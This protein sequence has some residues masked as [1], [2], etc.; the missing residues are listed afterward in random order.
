[1]A[2]GLREQ[3]VIVGV[4]GHPAASRE[5]VTTALYTVATGT[6]V[7]LDVRRGEQTLQLTLRAVQPPERL[8][9]ELLRDAVGLVT[10]EG[11]NGLA[12]QRVIAGSEA[13][14]RGLRP[15]D[16]VL[17]ANG[18]RARTNAELSREV[19]RGI[20]RGGLLLAVQRG[21]YV[22]NLGFSL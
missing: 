8:G 15:G 20:E 17:G 2:A 13:A 16:V 22:Y 21:R 18:Q 19:L 6:P 12:V 14:E 4:N 1:V 9:M 11:R 7:R 10:E 3:D 5:E